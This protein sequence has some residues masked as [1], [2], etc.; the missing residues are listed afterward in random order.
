MVMSL[1]KKQDGLKESIGESISYDYVVMGIPESD[2]GDDAV[3]RQFLIG[4]I[5][6]IENNIKLTG[7]SIGKQTSN[8]SWEATAE[9]KTDKKS[10][11]NQLSRTF[12]TSGNTV[13]KTFSIK[14]VYARST[15]YNAESE[16]GKPAEVGFNGE[17]VEGVD[18]GVAGFKFTET[19]PIPDSAV[20]FEYEQA[21]SKASWH[22]NDA[23]FRGYEAGEVLFKGVSG[24]K[25]GTEKWTLN[26]EFEVIHNEKNVAIGDIVVAEKKGWD[27]A[28]VRFTPKLSDD[29]SGI[30]IKIT[31]VFVDQV[32]PTADFSSLGIGTDDWLTTVKN[33]T[34]DAENLLASFPFGN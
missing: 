20:T 11:P 19:H 16:E 15:I 14:R 7:I 10:F 9:Y 2:I 4:N 34:S 21:L 18:V 23:P 1:W 26:F 25:N 17:E 24:S 32:Y 27:Y 8:S 33:S 30:I 6:T 13:H 12:D 3:L 28:S 29:N 22:V 31:G 5:P